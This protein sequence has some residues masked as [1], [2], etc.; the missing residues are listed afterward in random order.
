MHQKNILKNETCNKQA[1]L[2]TFDANHNKEEEKEKEVWKSREP[3]IEEVSTDVYDE[4]RSYR[5]RS[6]DKLSL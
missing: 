6:Q 5:D 3:P 1:A 2:P 4:Q